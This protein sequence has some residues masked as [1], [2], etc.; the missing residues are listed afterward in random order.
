MKLSAIA[1]EPKLIELLVDDEET[2]KEFGEALSFHTWDRQPMDI[3]V[4]LANLSQGES[5]SKNIN[6][7]EM[8][9]IVK[10]LILDENGKEL[11]TEQTT[12]PT[13]VLLKVIEKVS[14]LLGK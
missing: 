9:G 7:A 1:T 14:S 5:D 4:Q 6:I 10:C 8:L 13:H 3:F 2:V 12:L 11:I